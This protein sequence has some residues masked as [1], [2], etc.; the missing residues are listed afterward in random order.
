VKVSTRRTG[1]GLP[2]GSLATTPFTQSQSG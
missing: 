2:F 1:S